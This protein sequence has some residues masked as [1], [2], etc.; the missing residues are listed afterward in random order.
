MDYKKLMN[1]NRV[2]IE[3][4]L[5]PVQGSRFQPTG[6][7]NLGAATFTTPD[8]VDMLLVESPQSM[9][10]R[11]ETV[12][13]NATT[14]DLAVELEGLPYVRVQSKDGRALTNS[15]LESHRLNSP[16]I[17]EGGDRTFLEMLKGETGTMDF[18]PVNMR[19]VA[20]VVFKYDPNALLHGI[21][22]AK[23]ELAGGRLRLQRIISSFIEA[24]DV[25]P[26]ESGGVK[27]D[28]VDPKGNTAKGFGHVPFHRTE[29]TAGGTTAYFS[30]DTTSLKGY[31]LQPEAERLLIALAFWKI[32]RFLATGLRLR[33]AAD[34]EVKSVYV[35]RPDGFDLPTEDALSNWLKESIAACRHVGL[36]ADPAVTTVTYHPAE[37]SKGKKSGEEDE[38]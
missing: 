13:W 30:L 4:E 23:K 29:Y 21:F 5:V 17:L 8:G 25:K 34:F 1:V 26:V 37:Q 35:S 36:F 19:E 11:L 38:N 6:F 24:K 12:C 16:Y 22:F 10:N 32:R 33:T 3:A 31:N 20:R 15:I 2:L 14:D 27:M 18:G 7:P 9:A 28:R